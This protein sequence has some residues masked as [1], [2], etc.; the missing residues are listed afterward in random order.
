MT[1]VSS[2]SFAASISRSASLTACTVLMPSSRA[3][4]VMRTAI[5]P[6]LAMSSLAIGMILPGCSALQLDERLARHDR[7]LVLDEEPGVSPGLFGGNGREGLHDLDEPDG[8]THGDGVAVVLERRLIRCRPPVEDAGDW[9][10]DRPDSHV[11]SPCPG[12]SSRLGS[13]S[14]F[15][16]GI[17]GKGTTSCQGRPARR[18]ADLC[19]TIAA[20]PAGV[21]DIRK[22]C[23]LAQIGANHATPHG[24]RNPGLDRTLYREIGPAF[25]GLRTTL[26]TL[27]F[28]ALLGIQRPKHLKERDPAAL[29]RLLGLDRA[30]EVKTLRRKLTRLRS[31][32]HT[33]ELQSLRHLVCRLLLEK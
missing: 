11:S 12:S 29:G 26:L 33:S 16:A 13:G 25:Y 17:R 28:M 15:W 4:R 7:L 10:M 9:R 2:A 22:R 24:E 27:L 23:V 6:R 18:W 21:L 3:A 1:M 5:S 32:E 31:E 14:R 8:V 20:T 19:G 30:P